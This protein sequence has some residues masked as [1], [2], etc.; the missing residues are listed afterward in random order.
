MHSQPCPSQGDADA[1]ALKGLYERA[2]TVSFKNTRHTKRPH[3]RHPGTKLA[4]RPESPTFPTLSHRQFC[5]F[6][7]RGIL[8]L[9]L[10]SKKTP[11][12]Q[13]DAAK[14]NE[15]KAQS[16]YVRSLSRPP[17][18]TNDPHVCVVPQTQL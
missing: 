17:H 7:V 12:V 10:R 4:R 1:Y 6:F 5:T 15:P 11:K 8:R 2:T 14:A 9:S 16:P 18:R 3:E 13:S